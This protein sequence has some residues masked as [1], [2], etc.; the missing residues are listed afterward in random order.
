MAFK[1]PHN[2]ID[3]VATAEYPGELSWKVMRL[4]VLYRPSARIRRGTGS[5]I[6]G[7]ELL[8][9]ELVSPPRHVYEVAGGIL[10]IAQGFA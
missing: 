9:H 4:A 5:H 8:G 10:S 7:Y 2:G 1:L 6:L 3:V